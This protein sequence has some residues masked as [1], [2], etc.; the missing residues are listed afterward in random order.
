[1]FALRACKKLGFRNTV[2]P[3]AQNRFQKYGQ[4]HRQAFELSRGGLNPASECAFEKKRDFI[5]LLLVFEPHICLHTRGNRETIQELRPF[6]RV[7][8]AFRPH[9]FL[10]FKSADEAVRGAALRAEKHDDIVANSRDVG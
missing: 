6:E 1:L 5:P 10:Q 9:Q 8:N 3:N 2:S 7:K 4:V